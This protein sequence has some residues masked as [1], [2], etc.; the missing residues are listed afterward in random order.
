MVLGCPA[1]LHLEAINTLGGCVRHAKVFG[2]LKYQAEQGIE[3]ALIVQE[4]RY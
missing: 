4:G 1:N 3:V 2:K